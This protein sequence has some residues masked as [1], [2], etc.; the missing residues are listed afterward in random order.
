MD[1][2][3]NRYHGTKIDPIVSAYVTQVNASSREE[4]VEAARRAFQAES[5]PAPFQP[6]MGKTPLS[7]VVINEDIVAEALPLPKVHKP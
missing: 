5:G 2:G 1:T 6:K 4:A 3:L 7:M